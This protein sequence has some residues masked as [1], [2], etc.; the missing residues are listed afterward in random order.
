MFVPKY[1]EKEFNGVASYIIDEKN[2]EIAVDI[3]NLVRAKGL[4]RTQLSWMIASMKFYMLI[5]KRLK[6]SLEDID[7]LSGC[8]F[9]ISKEYDEDE[10]KLLSPNEKEDACAELFHTVNFLREIINI[11][12]QQTDEK[13]QGTS[14]Y[15]ANAS[16]NHGVDIVVKRLQQVVDA[17]RLLDKYLGLMPNFVSSTKAKPKPKIKSPTKGDGDGDK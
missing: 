1:Q 8:P 3:Y 17:E 13:T 2:Y 14:Y 7:A 12:S 4:E 9:L 10:F 11:F 15:C 16:S 6:P 5:N